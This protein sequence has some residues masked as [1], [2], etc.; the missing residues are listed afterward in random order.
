VF[1]HLFLTLVPDDALGPPILGPFG[2][3]DARHRVA[4]LLAGHV[5]APRKHRSCRAHIIIACY[6]RTVHSSY[7][8]PVRR[9]TQLESLP[10]SIPVPPAHSTFTTLTMASLPVDVQ[11]PVN[12]GEAI[13][14]LAMWYVS[15]PVL[16][17]LDPSSDFLPRPSRIAHSLYFRSSRSLF[18]SRAHT[19]EA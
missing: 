17:F 1:C 12:G 2:P 8:L 16:A 9:G 13:D 4:W 19:G 10:S 15:I 6:P 14:N 18:M 5:N 11:R 7:H 3:V